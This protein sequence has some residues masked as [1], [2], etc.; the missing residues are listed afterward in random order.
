MK[1]NMKTKCLLFASSLLLATAVESSA[2]I[3]LN[4]DSVN[5][6]GGPV[7]PTA[8]LAGYGITVTNDNHPGSLQILSDQNYYGGGVV[9]ASSP[10][11]FLLQNTIGSPNG[12]TYTLNFST[13][14]T[15]LSFTRIAQT[16]PNLVAQ[17]TAT[18]YAGAT[19]VGSVSENTFG[20]TEPAHTY[21][22]ADGNFLTDGG[23]TSLTITANGQGTAG[24]PSAPIDDLT[25]N[26]V[27]EPG[28][29]LFGFACVGV[30][31]LRRRRRSA[32]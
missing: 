11:N 24:I 31:A 32:V 23:I 18:A 21:S 27:P 16:T 2:G 12:T 17:W 6:S 30:A 10:H 3:I 5:A 26:A 13:A 8:Y 25:L 15:D 1:T 4:F 29:A 9:A 20:G 7:N 22:I 19:V 28:T 14:L